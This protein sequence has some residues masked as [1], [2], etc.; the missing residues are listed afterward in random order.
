M[1][2][3]KNRTKTSFNAALKYYDKLKVDPYRFT[4]RIYGIL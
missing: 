4:R 1:N 3:E 2:I